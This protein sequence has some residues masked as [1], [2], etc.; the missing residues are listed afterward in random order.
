MSVQCKSNQCLIIVVVFEI[1]YD[2][3]QQ[4]ERD[5]RIECSTGISLTVV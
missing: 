5:P 2:M 1:V 4:V 3:I